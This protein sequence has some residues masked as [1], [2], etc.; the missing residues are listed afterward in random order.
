MKQRENQLECRR[1]KK[2]ACSEQAFSMYHYPLILVIIRQN[3]EFSGFCV[4]EISIYRI[5]INIEMGTFVIVNPVKMGVFSNHGSGNI[6]RANQ[7]VNAPLIYIFSRLCASRIS[8]SVESY[9]FVILFF[10]IK[11][12]QS[13]LVRR[14]CIR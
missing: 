8:R 7:L 5:R 10:V 4:Q 13:G 3:G 12:Q 6:S 11:K 2:K 9:R 1:S 14:F